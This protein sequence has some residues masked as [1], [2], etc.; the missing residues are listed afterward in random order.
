MTSINE[1]VELF[2]ALVKEQN[3]EISRHHIKSVLMRYSR[4]DIERAYDACV[5][6]GIKNLL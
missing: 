6:F 2:E 5:R 3:I 4:E 1:Y